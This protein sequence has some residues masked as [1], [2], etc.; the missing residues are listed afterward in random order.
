MFLPT[1]HKSQRALQILLICFLPP[2]PPPLVFD[3]AAA[4]ER[5]H[6]TRIFFILLVLGADCHWYKTPPR[7]VGKLLPSF[8]AFLP[9]ACVR[10]KGWGDLGG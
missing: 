3:A 4:G 10:F 8:S 6:Q 9:A 5:R 7:R 2:P 1:K